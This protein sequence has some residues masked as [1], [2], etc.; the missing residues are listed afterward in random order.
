MYA[1]ASFLMLD[2]L[3]SLVDLRV[4]VGGCGA[5]RQSANLTHSKK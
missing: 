3:K 5:G 1:G 2:V 4:F